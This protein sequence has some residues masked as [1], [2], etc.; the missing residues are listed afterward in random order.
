MTK[1]MP[2]QNLPIPLISCLITLAFG[3]IFTPG[4]WYETLNR[5]PWNPPNIVFPIVWAMLYLFIA[6]SGWQIFSS[7]ISKLKW[8]WWAQLSINAI[9]SWIFFGQHWVLIGLIDIV[10][11]NIILITLITG[12]FK[13]KLRLSA[14]LLLP[15]LAWLI[16]ATTLNGYI[17]LYN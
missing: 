10:I 13:Y 7:Q 4:E 14:L 5:A 6:T 1:T 11:L 17:L 12:C 9:W 2:L 8:L 16:L 15:Y 3:G